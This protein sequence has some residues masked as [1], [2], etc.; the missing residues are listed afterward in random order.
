MGNLDSLV[1]ADFNQDGKLKL[2]GIG[3]GSVVV[4]LGNGDGTFHPPMVTDLGDAVA[5]AVGDVNGDGK[6]DLV[7][8]G[9]GDTLNVLLG[10]G[11]GQ[12]DQADC[13]PIIVASFN[14]L[15]SSRI[16]TATGSSIFS[17]PPTSK[18]R[19]CSGTATELF[20][21]PPSSLPETFPSLFES[22]TWT[23]TA[24]PTSWRSTI[25]GVRSSIVDGAATL[26]VGTTAP[27]SS[28]WGI[29]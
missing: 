2:A 9:T 5:I 24:I 3:G 28:P 10:L 1:A 19:S 29:R 13:F 21:A 16:S 20:R 14:S 18:S 25:D 8:T 26:A 6:P 23:P 17:S 12:F 27:A 22:G 11:N 7:A 4:V 15:P